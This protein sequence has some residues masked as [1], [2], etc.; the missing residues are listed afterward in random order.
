M[1][2]VFQVLFGLLLCVATALWLTYYSNLPFFWEKQSPDGS[3]EISLWRSGLL[4][5]LLLAVTQWLSSRVF[6]RIRFR[7][8]TA[9]RSR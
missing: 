2:T 1:K 5:L 6:R 8:R 3:Y 7:N 4:F 9:P